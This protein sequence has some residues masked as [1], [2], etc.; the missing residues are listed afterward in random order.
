MRF[1]CVYVDGGKGH[2]IPAK[3]VQEQLIALGH[4]AILIEFFDLFKIKWIGKINKK[5]WRLML[6][7]P[8]IEN[9]LSKHNDQDSNGMEVATK[10]LKLF[11]KN[12]FKKTIKNYNPDLIFTTHPY[13]EVFI[14][15]ML[16]KLKIN[17]PVTYYATDV[18][19]APVATIC[20]K[21]TK[22][23]IST[24]EG[25]EIVKGLGQDENKLELSPFPLQKSCAENKIKS[26]AEARS[27][28]GLKGDIFTLQINYGGEGLGTNTLLKSLANIEKE[29]QVVILGGMNETTKDNLK[30]ISSKMPENIHVHIIGFTDK[31]NAYAIAS[32]IIAGRAGINTILEAFYLRRP[33]LI[34]ELVYTVKASADYILK[35]NVGWNA[36][37]DQE[38]QFDIIKECIDNPTILE[39][40]DKNFDSIPIEYG[41][42]K[43]ALRLVELAKKS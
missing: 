28:L 5:V 6:R 8:K 18:F 15:E 9:N 3:A 20:N 1:L 39:S 4:E 31:V 35:Y 33:F 36:H 16:D 38:K 21:I 32:D 22:Y 27:I 19:S 37:L 11:S 14:A 42:D 41:A 29:I 2:Y 17:I 26:K 10:A 40:M 34:T 7:S 12:S 24:L 23:Y 25:L 30:Q 43:L 13:P